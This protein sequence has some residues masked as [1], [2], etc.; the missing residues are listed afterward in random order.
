MDQDLRRSEVWLSNRRRLASTIRAVI[1]GPLPQAHCCGRG[2]GGGILLGHG[3]AP[4]GAWYNDRLKGLVV[5]CVLLL[6]KVVVVVAVV[7]QGI[8][9][10]LF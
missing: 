4:G 7:C 6:W 10:L 1:A 9:S 5:L 8:V 3:V 2:W